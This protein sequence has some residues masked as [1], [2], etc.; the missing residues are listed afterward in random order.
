MCEVVPAKGR[1]THAD[2]WSSVKTMIRVT[3]T[4]II[5]DKETECERFYVSSRTLTAKQAQEFIRAH[6]S[7]EN[8]LH[9]R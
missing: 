9:W 7:I 1:M 6:W 8:S 4:R 2:K 3:S 5:K